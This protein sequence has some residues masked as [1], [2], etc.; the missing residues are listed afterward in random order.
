ML[1]TGDKMF[2]SDG[3]CKQKFKAKHFLIFD[4]VYSQR[5]HII[6]NKNQLQNLTRYTRLSDKLGVSNFYMD[7]RNSMELGRRRTDVIIL[8]VDNNQFSKENNEKVFFVV[9]TQYVSLMPS[10]ERKQFFVV[11]DHCIYL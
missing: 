9:H 11:I 5:M 8:T 2:S 10:F 4:M 6:C 3:N 7:H 1:P